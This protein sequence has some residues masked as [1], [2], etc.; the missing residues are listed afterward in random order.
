MP[1]QKRFKPL[2]S[3]EPVHLA[4]AAQAPGR[5]DSNEIVRVTLLLRPRASAEE[6]SAALSDIAARL[7]RDR[8]KIRA[9]DL[10]RLHG[11][12][13]ADLAAIGEFA[14][15]HNL[16]IEQ[17][18]EATG[19]VVLAGRLA[20]V[21][22]AFGVE[23]V[24]FQHPRGAYRSHRGPVHVPETLAEV[25]ESV[26]GLDD[27]P[28]VERHVIGRRQAL[29]HHT[30]P[31]DVARFYNFPDAG[32]QGQTIGI[33]ELGG[34]FH[35][36][37]IQEYFSRHNLRQP[38]IDVVEIARAVNAPASAG[39]IRKFWESVSSGS[40]GEGA[41]GLDIERIGWTIE[42]TMDVELAGA[43]A[44]GARIVVY[45]APNTAQGKYQAFAAA[46]GDGESQPSVVS[47]SW[48]A[49]EET[50]SRSYVKSLQR[51]F[52]VAV[53]RGVTIC[54]SSGDDGDG[55]ASG[56]KPQVNF[57][58]S[59]EFVLAC[60]GT[61]LD[62]SASQKAESVWSET[63]AGRQMASTGGAS[64]L[65]RTPDW[66]ARADVRTKTG[67]KGRG[68]PDVAAK[69]DVAT[70]YGILAGGIEIPMGGTSAAAPLWAALVARVNEKLGVPAG[71]VTPLVYRQEFQT[72]FRDVTEGSNGARFRAG[73]G[74]DPCTGW[75]SP[76]G[77]ALLTALTGAA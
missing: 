40:S 7:P 75:G 13:P 58:A 24:H 56:G 33:I 32:G 3:S 31:V 20:D 2:A 43:L 11:P 63:F 74:W 38:R 44:N 34:G 49:H 29:Q 27:Q 30:E 6:R 39:D 22:R 77:I 67:Q 60:G 15:E 17:T 4:G 9:A 70:G 18:S 55:A 21:S 25:V 28:V 42:T 45:F 54:C 72:S 26:L 69:A 68:V 65:F 36:S 51:L 19:H 35:A 37:D 16:K 8:R 66:Q 62:L 41:N 1:P 73:P 61:H 64:K 46:L 50:L 59:S 52:E 76:N 5:P 10:K 53:Q 57:P 71:Y 12:A 47:C 23:L 48:G 14:R